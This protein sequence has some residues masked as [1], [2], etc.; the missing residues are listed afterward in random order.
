MGFPRQEHWN[1]LLSPSPGEAFP[2]R[3]QAWISDVAC[4]G[5]QHSCVH[6]TVGGR[7]KLDLVDQASR[8]VTAAQLMITFLVLFF[9]TSATWETAVAWGRC[10]YDSHLRDEETEEWKRSHLF[11]VTQLEMEELQVSA[12]ISAEEKKQRASFL[13][14]N[15]T[16]HTHTEGQPG[17]LPGL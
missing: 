1:G 2:P 17:N 10:Q 16:L 3:D 13:H 8:F 15:A 14:P 5:S 4:P 12:T 7:S 11:N 9:T 6:A